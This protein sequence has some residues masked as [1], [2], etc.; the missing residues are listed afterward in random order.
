MYPAVSDGRSGSLRFFVCRP[1]GQGPTRVGILIIRTRFRLGS[2]ERRSRDLSEKVLQDVAI[3]ES[4]M[5]AAYPHMPIEK[6]AL[7]DVMMVIRGGVQ[8]IAQP[9]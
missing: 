9:E 1:L 4:A 3:L 7:G 8:S 6:A 5:K 2:S